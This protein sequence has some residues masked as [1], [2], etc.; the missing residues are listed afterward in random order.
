[1][2]PKVA[3]IVAIKCY[4]NWCFTKQP[5]KSS[6]FWATFVSKFGTKNFQKSPNLVTLAEP[7]FRKNSP[8]RTCNDE[9]KFNERGGF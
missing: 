8:Q 2:L 3:Q 4:I 5:K 9:G 6:F 7:R 1:M